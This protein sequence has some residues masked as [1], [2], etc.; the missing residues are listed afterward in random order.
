[1]KPN[2]V[3]RDS[4]DVSGGSRPA[5]HVVSP[6]TLNALVAGTNVLTLDGALPVEYLAPGDRV[7]TRNA[8]AAT[9]LGIRR[10][11]ARVRLVAIKAGTLGNCR[12]D[13][14]ALLPAGQEVLVRDWRAG[15]LFGASRA[16]APAQRLV[17]GQFIRV[18]GTREVDLVELMLDGPHIL[19]GDGLELASAAVVPA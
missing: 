2:M 16:L 1:M 18:I 11:R 10:Y 17:D 14:D 13:R 8:G 9:L 4:T 12:P 6:E 5:R 15:A 19:Y 3:R 7:I